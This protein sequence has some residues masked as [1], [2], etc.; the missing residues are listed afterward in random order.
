MSANKFLLCTPGGGGMSRVERHP[1]KTLDQDWKRY[2]QSCGHPGGRI[3]E[4]CTYQN[5]VS[6][7]V[8]QLEDVAATATR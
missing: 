7:R 5:T 8:S 2:I 1:N 6:L 4:A 3:L